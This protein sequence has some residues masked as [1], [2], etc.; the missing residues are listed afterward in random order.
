MLWDLSSQTVWPPAEENMKKELVPS[1]LI[2]LKAT[3]TNQKYSRRQLQGE[4]RGHFQK[5][6]E[7]LVSISQAQGHTRA[8]KMD[9]E[10]K[11]KSRIP[12]STTAPDSTC[13][14]TC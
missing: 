6:K 3:H 1:L 14:R 2:E 5:Q 12:D 8:P 10:Q 13:S 7:G 4:M 11:A 9:L